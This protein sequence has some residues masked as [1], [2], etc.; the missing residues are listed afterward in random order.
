MWTLQKW[1]SHKGYSI[2]WPR[3]GWGK[4]GR[5]GSNRWFACRYTKPRVGVILKTH[6]K[7]FGIHRYSAHFFLPYIL[8]LSNGYHFLF[9]INDK[10]EKG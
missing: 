7:A 3:V 9:W 1:L 6:K 5:E 2:A 10:Y 4:P 8:L